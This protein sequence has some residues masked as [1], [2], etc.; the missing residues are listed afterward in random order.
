MSKTTSQILVECL[1]AAEVKR[2]YGLIGT[3]ITPFYAALVKAKDDIRYISTRHEL[4]AC[5][6]ADAEGRLTGRPGV[7]LL[8]SGAGAL[9]GALGLAT[10]AKDNSPL[11]LIVGGVRRKLVGLGG[12][13]EMDHEHVFASYVKGFHRVT[14]PDHAAE[15][16]ASAW[17]QA[18]SLPAGPVVL[19]VPE[20]LWD[21]QGNAECR[22]QN[23]E[24]ALPAPQLDAV[25]EGLQKSERPLL[26]VGGGAQ[27]LGSA[28]L[29]FVEAARL[30]VIST[31]NGRGVVPEDHHLSFGRAGYAGGNAIA[32]FALERADFAVF[33]GCGLS[34]MLT[35][36]YTRQPAGGLAFINA[37]AAY[38]AQ[39]SARYPQALCYHAEAG[40]ALEQLAAS[41]LKGL[42]KQPWWDQL[43]D[44]RDGWH[45]YL[46]QC[47]VARKPM[48]SYYPLR[49]LSMQIPRDA[50]VVSGTGLH[51]LTVN[52]ALPCLGPRQFLSACNFGA[53]G[54]GFGAAMAARLIYPE[55]VVVCAIG[56][57]DFLM[58]SPDLETAV[59]EDIMPL[60]VILNDRGYG[61]LRSQEMIRGFRYGADH[62]N[63]DFSQLAAAYGLGH[64]RITECF[65]ADA[66]FRKGLEPGGP[67][68]IEVM[69]DAAEMPPSNWAALAAMRQG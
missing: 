44:A 13:L 9:N 64:M 29:K 40:A 28:V 43:E 49:R 68:I 26:V 35:Y 7:L 16:F 33:L 46:D 23:A 41:G 51:I 59:R 8:H 3:S 2:I 69:V 38:L 18:T 10:A 65:E 47:S 37:D 20:D 30:P 24:S 15:A 62:G 14:G 48:P 60:T 45:H 55:R 12:M 5:A 56:D 19:E 22:I 58:T 11:L 61:A 21:V 57:G 63:P 34:D 67:K 36:Q 66:A 1:R 50:I 6:M 17:S 42:C 31:G 53:M 25:V 32:D 4:V 39:L 27:H 54:F 52:A